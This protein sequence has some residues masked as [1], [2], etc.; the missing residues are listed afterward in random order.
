MLRGVY[1][2]AHFPDSVEV[3]AAAAAKVLPKHAVIC[4]RTAAWLHGVN[5]LDP[6]E[7]DSIP[8]LEAVSRDG[9]TT[10][11]AGVYG[12]KRS[13]APD[14]L[15]LIGG[16]TVTTPLRTALDLASLRGEAK[17][18][19]VL[20]AFSRTHGL[21]QAD[22]M[23]QLPR[24][25]GRRGV[26]QLR[27]LIPWTT[28][29]SESPGESWCR[30]AILTDGL[31]APVPQFE[32]YDADRLLCRLDLAYPQLKI[33]VEYDGVEFHG[34]DQEDHDRTRRAW[35]RSQGWH[36]IVVRKEDLSGPRRDAWLM[37]LRR[38]IH[39]RTWRG[40]RQYPRAPRP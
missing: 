25:R 9:R 6:H 2:P 28:P 17:A 39:E 12:C 11:R 23:R 27:K 8:D 5:A 33:A 31:P 34:P 40:K 30:W 37:E 13:L 15:M 21:D 14:D 4:D 38:E 24:Y 1:V 35:L 29:L 10:G 16:I 26:V 32:I 36:V 22:F 20:D 19:S 18:L 7:R 3:R